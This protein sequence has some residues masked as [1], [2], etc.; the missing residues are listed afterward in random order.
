MATVLQPETIVQL[1]ADGWFLYEKCK[2]GGKL[3][4][5]Y[6]HNDHP[7]YA[8]W[9]YPKFFEFRILYQNKSIRTLTPI[10]R[11]TDTLKT[12]LDDAA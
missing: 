2:C 5:K 12:V 4:Y 7:G 11:L 6:H 8:V 3:K 1:L 10:G 9:W